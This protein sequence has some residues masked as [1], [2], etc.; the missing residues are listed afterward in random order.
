M[1][2]LG[3]GY[4]VIAH[5]RRGHGPSTQTA[6]G[7]DMDSTPQIVAEVVKPLT[8]EHLAISAPRQRGEVTHIRPAVNGRVVKRGTHQ[9]ISSTFMK[10]TAIPDCGQRAVVAG[11]RDGNANNRSAVL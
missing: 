2:F 9:W 5:Y 10:S 7:H 8:L 1:F 4:R 6:N 11:I 3:H